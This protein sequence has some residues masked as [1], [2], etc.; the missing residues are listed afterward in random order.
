MVA[1]T[2][3]EL[4]TVIIGGLGTIGVGTISYVIKRSITTNATKENVLNQA[5]LLEKDIQHHDKEILACKLNQSLIESRFIELK[6]SFKDK[7][8]TKQ[9]LKDQMKLIDSKL[10]VIL[11]FV[12]HEHIQ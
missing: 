5:R 11:K 10:E 8:V 9:E 4:F 3:I 6:D 1:N 7:Y 12:R 2:S